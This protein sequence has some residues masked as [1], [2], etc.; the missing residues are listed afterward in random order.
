V[1]EPAIDLIHY[2][3]SPRPLSRFSR[4]LI[5][6]NPGCLRMLL[7]RIHPTRWNQKCCRSIRFLE[8]SSLCLQPNASSNGA[9]LSNRDRSSQPRPH[10]CRPCGRPT[11]RHSRLQPLAAYIRR[12]PVI[13]QNWNTDACSG[14]YA[15]RCIIFAELAA[16]CGH[17]VN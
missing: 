9:P 16:A 11:T 8:P 12:P 13:P 6:K 14:A 2:R 7:L 17:V 4:S 15:T 10:R 3:P 1:T 5:S